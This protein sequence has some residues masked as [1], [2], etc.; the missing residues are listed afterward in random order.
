MIE[1]LEDDLIPDH[2]R[3]QTLKYTKPNINELNIRTYLTD[4]ELSLIASDGVDIVGE[5]S[6]DDQFDYTKF[7]QY[8]AAW[9]EGNDE[10]IDD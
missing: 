10:S 2:K 6:V 4:D 9:E 8:Y 7:E 5:L 1:A 3:V